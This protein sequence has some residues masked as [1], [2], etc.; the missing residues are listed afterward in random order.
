MAISGRN[1]VGLLG[2]HRENGVG[3]A[4]LASRSMIITLAVNAGRKA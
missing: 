2:W 4:L 3:V 1:L